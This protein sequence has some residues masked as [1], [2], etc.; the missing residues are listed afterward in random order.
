MKFGH[1]FKKALWREGFPAHW[2]ESAVPYNQLKKCI[3]KVESELRDLGLG[4]ETLRR[5]SSPNL[6]EDHETQTR[7]QRACRSSDTVAFEYDFA[8]MPNRP[9][10]LSIILIGQVEPLKSGD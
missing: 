4:S 6:N 5:L 8:G 7:K 10:P 2:I 9:H 3:K 1:E